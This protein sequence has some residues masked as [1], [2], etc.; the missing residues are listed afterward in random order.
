MC[1]GGGAA[2][3]ARKSEERLRAEQDAREGR[4]REGQSAIDAAFSRFNDDYFNEYARNVSG[5]LRP[6]VMDEYET[7]RGATVAS[8]AGRGMLDSTEGA[9]T[10]TRLETALADTLGRVEDRGADAARS[11]RGQVEDQR[12]NLYSMNLAAA[13]PS[14]AGAQ[15]IGSATALVAPRE[16]TPLEGAFSGFLGPVMMAQQA[17]INSP[18]PAPASTARVPTAGS[19]RVVR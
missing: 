18:R 6:G 8:L 19:G 11:L 12:S 3:Q 16:V 17:R 14:A 2:D 5:S 15:A 13:D 7:T 10:T 1:A 9:R 4:I